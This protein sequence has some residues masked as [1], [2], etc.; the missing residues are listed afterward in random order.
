MHNPCIW[1]RRVLFWQA[2]DKWRVVLRVGSLEVDG[3]I[4]KLGVIGV[5]VLAF[6]LL[7]LLH[8]E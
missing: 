7:T 3:V 2:I 6:P 4:G 1:Q 5:Q 8:L